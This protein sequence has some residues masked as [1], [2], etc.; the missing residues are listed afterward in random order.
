MPPQLPDIATPTAD[1][2]P[3][4][5][6]DPLTREEMSA[7]SDDALCTINLD[8]PGAVTQILASLPELREVEAQVLLRWREPPV[9]LVARL[10]RYARAL[11]QAHDACLGLKAI[12]PDI[13]GLVREL[14]GVRQHLLCC[15]QALLVSGALAPES[16]APYQRARGNRS[17]ARSVCGIVAVCR[18]QWR[19][20]EHKTPLTMAELDQAH[21]LAQRLLQ[22]LRQREAPLEL[23]R[24]LR[25]RRQAFTLLMREYAELRRAAQ[26]LYPAR[27]AERRVPSLFRKRSRAPRRS[28]ALPGAAGD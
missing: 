11:L 8:I 14:G 5:V 28:P 25:E 15:M 27:E 1:L 20:I 7:L 13:S 17:L 21:G 9:G 24:A 12:H 26:F 16:L 19:S 10:E 6:V 23:T 22:G 18:A 2:L 4:P 3:L